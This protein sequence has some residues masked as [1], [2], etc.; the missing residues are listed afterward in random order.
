LLD[1]QF[2]DELIFISVMLINNSV[3][4]QVEEQRRKL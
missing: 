3:S 4:Q 2:L 1:V